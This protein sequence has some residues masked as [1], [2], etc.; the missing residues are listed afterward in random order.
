MRKCGGYFDVYN[1]DSKDIFIVPFSKLYAIENDAHCEFLVFAQRSLS[2]ST[3]TSIKYQ[4]GK[5]WS[6]IF[7]H[8]NK[9]YLKEYIEIYGI[10]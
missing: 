9:K 4:N 8:N 7:A 10:C 6:V 5:L 2:N 1:L 3:P